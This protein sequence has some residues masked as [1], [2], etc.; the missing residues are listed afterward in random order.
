MLANKIW[1]GLEGDLEADLG[2]QQGGVLG[3]TDDPSIIPDYEKWCDV[4][5]SFDLE[6]SPMTGKQVADLIPGMARNWAGG[7]FV[8]GDGNA[9]ADITTQAFARAVMSR[10][11]RIETNCAV[12]DI[13]LQG[14]TG[15]SVCGVVTDRGSVKAPVVIVAAGAWASRVLGWLDLEMPQMRIRGSVARSMPV[16]PLTPVAAWT[17]SVGFVQRKDGCFTIGGLDI[18]DHDVSLESLRYARYF[19]KDLIKHR[20]MIRLHFGHPFLLDL[21]GR[22]PG[23]GAMND[24][25]RRARIGNARPNTRRIM[26]C[27]DNFCD[28]FPAIGDTPMKKAWAGHIDVTPDMLPVIDGE[29]GPRGLLVAAGFSGHGFGI[30]PGAGQMIAQLVNGHNP[31]VDLSDFSLDR[32]AKGTWQAPYNLI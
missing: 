22:L 4:A 16:A 5:R 12:L 11:G 19:F 25:L 23:S 20:H 24:P 15:G 7:I 17:P 18:S 26:K 28:L 10:G 6:C 27:F 8:P 14:G 13:E 29:A 3:I 30:G 9:D 32:F 31:A 21:V 1:Q 2:W